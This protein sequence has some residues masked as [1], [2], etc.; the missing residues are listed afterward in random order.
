MLE[1]HFDGWL[2][3]GQI[4]IQYFEMSVDGS[5]TVFGR[6]TTASNPELTV[7]KF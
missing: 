6:G 4:K 1:C 7:A 5:S 3:A 2:A